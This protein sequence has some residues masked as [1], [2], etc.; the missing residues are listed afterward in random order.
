MARKLGLVLLV[1]HYFL[2]KLYGQQEDCLNVLSEKY[3]IQPGPLDFG[4]AQEKTFL[5][6]LSKGNLNPKGESLWLKWELQTGSCQEKIFI[7]LANRNI[8]RVDFWQ[9]REESLVRQETFYSLESQLQDFPYRHLPTFLVDMKRPGKT[10]LY[11]NVISQSPIAMNVSILGEKERLYK[12][13]TSQVLFLLFLGISIGLSLYNLYLLILTRDRVY[14]FYV[15]YALIVTLGTI[16]HS[17]NAELFF[18]TGLDWYHLLHPLICLATYLKIRCVR[19]IL[20]LSLQAPHLDKYLRWYSYAAGLILILDL[21]PPLQYYSNIF[22]FAYLP[23]STGI[24]MLAAIVSYKRNYKPARIMLV[25][26]SI[27][28]ILV[29]IRF[30]ANMGLIEHNV[31]TSHAYKFSLGIELLLLAAVLAS[32]INFLQKELTQ[33]QETLEIKI[34]NRTKQLKKANKRFK[35]NQAY[36]IEQEK[37]AALGRI[38]DTL[39]H[40]VNTPLMII[41]TGASILSQQ[42]HQLSTQMLKRRTTQIER[43]VDK[44]E[45]I[46]K[47]LTVTYLNPKTTPSGK[48]VDIHEYLLSIIDL[49]R[50]QCLQ[51]EIELK[52]A[53]P[54]QLLIPGNPL[55]LADIISEFFSGAINAV[56]KLENR[57]IDVH[58]SRA[59]NDIVIYIKDSA[60][61]DHQDPRKAMLSSFASSSDDHLNIVKDSSA[62]GVGIAHEII[63]SYGGSIKFIQNAFYTQ[64]TIKFPIDLN[65]VKKDVA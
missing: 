51:H 59:K 36:I 9:L 15:S 26:W 12:E 54:D 57:W 33:L 13:I 40:E 55:H 41:R 48:Q 60:T 29:A 24:C 50:G 16:I 46:I 62:V 34:Q 38:A 44:I 4:Q 61:K 6:V 8:K 56:A 28:F 27:T 65:E 35:E 3:L 47:A 32:K 52:V 5:P 19:E 1:I 20:P 2:P 63:K 49:H 25:A 58:V 30:L 53:L 31:L 23:L 21:L 22:I 7:Q 17:R 10:E 14:V 11:L 39:A 18:G 43:A 45:K 64:A 37:F 42:A